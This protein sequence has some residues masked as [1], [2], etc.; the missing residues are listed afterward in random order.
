[1]RNFSGMFTFIWTIVANPSW[2]YHRCHFFPFGR[3][4]CLFVR[5]H[6]CSLLYFMYYIL[7]IDI[8]FPICL[9]LLFL[10]LLQAL[11]MLFHPVCKSAGEITSVVSP[12]E[13]GRRSI[14]HSSRS[15]FSTC[16]GPSF[17]MSWP[18]FFWN[19]SFLPC[20]FS[21]ALLKLL[22]D[23]LKGFSINL[24]HFIAVVIRWIAEDNKKKHL[25]S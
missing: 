15:P 4:L 11:L 19:R 9:Q 13:I 2:I 23:H 24:E 6:I 17:H 3:R 22:Q 10:C 25:W 5:H 14:F 18:N 20:R 16:T 12:R 1:M 21:I 7:H 8:P